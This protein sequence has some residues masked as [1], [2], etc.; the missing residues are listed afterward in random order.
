M[1][2]NNWFV[3]QGTMEMAG[4]INRGW[5]EAGRGWGW[6]RG[7]ATWIDTYSNIY[8]TVRYSTVSQWAPSGNKHALYSRVHAVGVY[9]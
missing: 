8:G 3:A 4:R 2:G 9:M 6:D 5:Y 7:P 1:R